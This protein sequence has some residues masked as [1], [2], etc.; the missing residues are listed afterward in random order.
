MLTLRE[1]FKTPKPQAFGKKRRRV[2]RRKK[3]TASRKA[4]EDPKGLLAERNTWMFENRS[5]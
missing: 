2:P 4:G 3:S 5:A 1:T